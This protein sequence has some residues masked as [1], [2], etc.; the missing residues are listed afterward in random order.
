MSEP[1][2]VFLCHAS[3][4]KPVVQELFK[5]LKSEDWVDPWLDREKILPGQDWQAAIEK[6]VDEADVIIIC[7]SNQSVMKDGYVQKEIRFAYDLALE[8][9][10]GTIFLIPLRLD[11]VSLIPRRLHTF[12]WMDYFGDQKQSEYLKLLASL[13]LRYEQKI[14]KENPSVSSGI[15]SFQQKAKLEKNAPPAFVDRGSY[16]QTTLTKLKTKDT[17]KSDRKAGQKVEEA[18]SGKPSYRMALIIFGIVLFVIM[19]IIGIISLGK[20]FISPATPTAAVVSTLTNA[21]TEVVTEAPTELVTEVPTELVTEVPTEMATET[22][23]VI[24]PT[25]SPPTASPTP[26]AEKDG[27]TMIDISAGEFMLG[28]DMGDADE[29]PFQT[30]FLDAFSIDQ[31]E[32]TNKMYSL[33]VADG[34]CVLPSHIGSPNEKVYYGNSKYE[35]Y[36][37]IYVNWDMAKAY[38][39]WAGRDLPTELQW[40]KAARGTN[41]LVYPWGDK[42]DGRLLNYCDVNC[43]NHNKADNRYNDENVNLAPV[44]YYQSGA[45]VYGV[46]DMSGNVWEWINDW[47]DVHPNGI[48][49]ASTYFG[50]KFHVIKGGSWMHNMYEARSSNRSYFSVASDAFNDYTGFRCV[51]SK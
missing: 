8:K 44:G 42:F 4:D 39:Q 2:R 15:D 45:S 37:V 22:L 27:M 31:T 13:R 5:A 1:L 46:L 12:Q 7:L 3:L 34:M 51:R 11:E 50:Q 17:Q 40:E 41:G 33:C 43:A 30:M 9:T 23:T 6:A 20:G 32:V 24:A 26:F 49:T 47:Y 16:Q 29:K 36:P 25:L 48:Q 14:K 19:C 35:N 18:P 38:C 21:P 10:E 28:S